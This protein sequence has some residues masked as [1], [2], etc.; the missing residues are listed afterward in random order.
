MSPLSNEVFAT[1]SDVLLMDTTPSCIRFLVRAFS[2]QDAGWWV[3]SLV[4][5]WVR[6]ADQKPVYNLEWPNAASPALVLGTST[7][8][9]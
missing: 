4:I 2:S 1:V 6:A 5:I 8:D 3:Y 9:T 7:V